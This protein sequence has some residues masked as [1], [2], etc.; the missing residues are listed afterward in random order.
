VIDAQNAVLASV[1][2]PNNN[3]LTFSDSAISSSTGASITFTRDPQGRIIGITDP[4]GATIHYSYSAQGDLASM[5]DRTGAVTQ[6]FY[7]VTP[8]HYLDHV[9]DP[10]GN[11]V[12]QVHYDSS[13]RL[14]GLVNAA[15]I[16]MPISTN[17]GALTQTVADGLGNATQV[18]YLC[19]RQSQTRE[20]MCR[21]RM[22]P[23]SYFAAT[24]GAAA[25]WTM[26][27]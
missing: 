10:K 25:L 8:A 4:S 7:D 12:L 6:F 21:F 18:T 27:A 26:A 2:D 13:G 3:T 17:P 1:I 14:D 19:K 20:K 9:V 5:T 11:T 22:T 16:L 24:T 23:P 15:G